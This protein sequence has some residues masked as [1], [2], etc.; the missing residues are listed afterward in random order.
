MQDAI[1]KP[2]ERSDISTLARFMRELYEF[3]RTPF[4]E[5]AARETLEKFLSGE[6]PA[7]IWLI[8]SGG[9]EIGYIVITF[10]CSLEFRG[11]DAFLDEIYITE[12][13][14]GRGVGRQALEFVEQFCRSERVEALHLAVERENRRAQEVYRQFGFKAHD[15]YLM[16][17]WI[18][19]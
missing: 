19:R 5:Q 8:E 6:M 7:R 16:T 13:N 17:K 2:A 9:K 15:R 1:F 4:D 10:G 18:S 11:K 3:D 12:N 14:R